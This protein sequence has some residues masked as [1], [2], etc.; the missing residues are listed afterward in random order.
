VIDEFEVVQCPD[1]V[2]MSGDNTGE[3]AASEKMLI[4]RASALLAEGVSK[5]GESG[6]ISSGTILLKAASRGHAGPV[7]VPV[8]VSVHRVRLPASV[9]RTNQ[10][11]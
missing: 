10:A 7:V 1:F 8:P 5:S 11:K 9:P 6:L 2:E 4:V 3:V